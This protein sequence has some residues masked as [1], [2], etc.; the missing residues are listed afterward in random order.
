MPIALRPTGEKK[1]PKLK[2]KILEGTHYLS[3]TRVRALST[4]KGGE[5]N[6]RLVCFFSPL[7]KE[8]TLCLARY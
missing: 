5:L 7:F 4:I 3:K 8:R 1:I 6:S 2:E